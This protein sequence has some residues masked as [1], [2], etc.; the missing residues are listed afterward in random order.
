MG[1]PPRSAACL[2]G[3]CTDVRLAS[4]RHPS[5]E[6]HP[7]GR[8]AGWGSRGTPP[9]ADLADRRGRRARGSR[10]AYAMS[11]TMLAARMNI[12]PTTVTPITMGKSLLVDHLDRELTQ[13]GEPEEGLGDDESGED[14]REVD[15]EHRHDRRQRPA[16]RVLV[17]DPALGEPLRP[18]GADVVLLG[19]FDHVAAEHPRVHRGGSRPRP[20]SREGGTCRSARSPTRSR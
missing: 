19:R 12:D 8:R 10:N 6:V 7:A 20:R 3:S 14:R 9:C 15:A 1:S 4:M 13:P 11:T 16:E 17:H 2:R 18:R 5:A